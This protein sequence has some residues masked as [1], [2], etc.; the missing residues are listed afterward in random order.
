MTSPAV[1]AAFGIAP[2]DTLRPG[3][4]R[5]RCTRIRYGLPRCRL[6]TFAG[7]AA[8]SLRLA[9]TFPAAAPP[10]VARSRRLI[11]GGLTE[12]LRQRELLHFAL[13]ELLDTAEL[14]LLLLVDE[15]QRPPRGARTRRTAD[16]VDIILGVVRH[17]VVDHHA[18]IF[19]V[20]ASR[21]DVGGHQQVD[22]AV[23]EIE[24]HLLALGL[25]QI[26]VHGRRIE[27]HPLE[28]ESQ[29]LDFQLRR[30]EDDR[31][32][33]ER[34]GEKFLYQ[35]QFLRFV[36]HVGPLLDRLIG[37]RDGDID[38]DGLAQNLPG[39]LADLGRQRSREHQRLPLGGQPADDGHDVVEESHVEHPV[40][41]VEHEI[42]HVRQVDAAVLQ[43]G[44]QTARRGDHHVGAAQHPLL[45]LL[46]AAAVAAAVDHRRRDGH[47]IGES[48]QLGV[49]LHGQLARGNHH[50]RLDHVVL[51]ALDEQLVEQ[52]QRVGRRLA[53]SGLCAGDQVAA[54]EDH[55]N[56]G[57]LHG[58]H[59]LEI[60]VVE[61]VE[62][63]VFEIYF[64]ES[65][66]LRVILS[67]HRTAWP[68]SSP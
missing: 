33:F 13:H 64:A 22:L 7:A 36:E 42:L 2:F 67:L 35:P 58:G 46:P 31:L 32:R 60:H 8:A 1:T 39:Q 59:L 65:H 68:T 53:R 37:F 57:L 55:R 30:G 24:H 45:L 34:F 28:G 54:F 4:R 40:G 16:A 41:L 19:D 14:A 3:D 56:G 66:N 51:V 48:L 25:I 63:L 20:D 18:Y 62:N 52:R 17:V 44:D 43:V 10:T 6:R 49:D 29:L 11:R 5:R 61:A 21:H 50:E 15:G 27:V 23:L 9:A 26:G 47:V 38:L 12:L